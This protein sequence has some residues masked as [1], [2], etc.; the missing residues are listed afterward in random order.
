MLK[1]YQGSPCQCLLL[2][3]RT[4]R[5]CLDV[6]FGISE[7]VDAAGQKYQETDIAQDAIAPI[8]DESRISL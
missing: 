6:I 4:Y 2:I 5:L 7:V 8:I 3:H 1:F